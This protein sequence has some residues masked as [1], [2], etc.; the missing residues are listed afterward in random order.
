M[1]NIRSIFCAIFL[2]RFPADE[3]FFAIAH[4]NTNKAM[5]NF[6]GPVV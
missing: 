5:N 3:G 1:I 4:L 2:Q 6:M